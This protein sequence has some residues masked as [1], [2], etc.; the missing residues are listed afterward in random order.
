MAD[1]RDALSRW[2]DL[3]EDVTLDLPRLRMLGDLQVLVENH[4][5]VRSFH[6]D[7][8]VVATKIG[9]LL[10][11]GAELRVGAVSED[12]VIVTGRIEGLRYRRG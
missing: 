8:A 9:D 1:L 10:I 3:P 4:Q 12:A 7:E 5:G 6:E 11:W 2:L